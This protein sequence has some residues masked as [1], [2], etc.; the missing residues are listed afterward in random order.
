[1]SNPDEWKKILLSQNQYDKVSG[2]VDKLVNLVNELPYK[3]RSRV[4]SYEDLLLDQEFMLSVFAEV[5][6]LNEDERDTLIKKDILKPDIL[7]YVH[8]DIYLTEKSFIKNL[9][10]SYNEFFY[11]DDY[12]FDQYPYPFQDYIFDNG[13]D[14][15]NALYV[16]YNEDSYSDL[17]A[18]HADLEEDLRQHNVRFYIDILDNVTAKS[19]PNS[20]EIKDQRETFSNILIWLYGGPVLG[21]GFMHLI[22]KSLIKVAPTANDNFN[23]SHDVFNEHRLNGAKIYFRIYLIEHLLKMKKLKFT[24]NRVGLNYFLEDYE[25]KKDEL[26]TTVGT[27]IVDQFIHNIAKV[28]HDDGRS[29][30][31]FHHVKAYLETY[32]YDKSLRSVK[33]RRKEAVNKLKKEDKSHELL[34]SAGH[35]VIG[36][37]TESSPGWQ[38]K[39]DEALGKE[40]N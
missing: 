23:Y 36:N 18:I 1:M 33:S 28:I 21:K 34:A 8:Y 3:E 14:N 26:N 7:P 13:R 17:K 37:G 12:D 30:Y 20:E 40:I 10:H 5:K 25:N 35:N 29:K 38:R 31:K 24:G 2:Y 32:Y 6:G 19:F 22:D 16:S 4:K 9:P 27:G 15:M 39:L 11:R